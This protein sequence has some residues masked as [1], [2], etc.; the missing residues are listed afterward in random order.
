MLNKYGYHSYII[1]HNLCLLISL[2][3][4]QQSK[5]VIIIVKAFFPILLVFEVFGKTLLKLS[6]R[7]KLHFELAYYNHKMHLLKV[8]SIHSF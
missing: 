3:L 6:E 4:E 1:K 7:L 5:I 2:Y 8:H